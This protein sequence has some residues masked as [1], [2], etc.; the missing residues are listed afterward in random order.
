[1]AVNVTA[2]WLDEA[3]L[4]PSDRPPIPRAPGAGTSG[5]RASTTANRIGRT[6]AKLNSRGEPGSREVLESASRSSI[7]ASMGAWGSSAGTRHARRARA[8]G[9][10]RVRPPPG[11]RPDMSQ[12]ETRSTSR[13]AAR[14]SRPGAGPSR[15][16]PSGEDPFELSAAMDRTCCGSGRLQ[17]KAQHHQRHDQRRPSGAS[18]EQDLPRRRARRGPRD[19]PDSTMTCPRGRSARRGVGPDPAEVGNRGMR[20]D[21]LR[22]GESS[23]RARACSPGPNA[24]P[25]WISTE[26]CAVPPQDAPYGRVR[27]V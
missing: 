27:R 15:R 8:T 20:E 14:R 26:P 11:V 2:I 5:V 3:T 17:R 4:R 12:L 7:V 10:S 1:M 13:F 25:A 19:R 23:A 18:S 24:R 6:A 22:R 16:H 9:S 21:D